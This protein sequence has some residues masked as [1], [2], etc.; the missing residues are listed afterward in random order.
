[1][2]RPINK[3]AAEIKALWHPRLV[4]GVIPGYMRFSRPYLEAMLS[5]Q[6]INDS[7]GLDP[8][9]GVVLYF[10]ANTQGWSGADARRIK[11]ELNE[12]LKE[13]SG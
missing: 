10:L 9:D 1:V 4:T 3:I 5:I 8:A 13:I 6:T 11:L 12:H 2:P 7:Y